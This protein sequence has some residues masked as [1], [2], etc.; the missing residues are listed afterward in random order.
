MTTTAGPG[1]S[2]SLLL[3]TQTHEVWRSEEEEAVKT[4]TQLLTDLDDGKC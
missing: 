2:L 4:Y 1:Q 3:R